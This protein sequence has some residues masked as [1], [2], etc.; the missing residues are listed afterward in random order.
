M[1]TIIKTSVSV[2]L[3]LLFIGSIGGME[4]ET[5]TTTMGIVMALASLLGLYLLGRPHMINTHA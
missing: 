4:R 3:A 5:I 2:L 1:K